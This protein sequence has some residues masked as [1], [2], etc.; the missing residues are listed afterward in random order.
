MEQISLQL[1]SA[2]LLLACAQAVEAQQVCYTT[3]SEGGSSAL[4]L[5]GTLILNDIPRQGLWAQPGDKELDWVGPQ[6][7]ERYDRGSSWNRDGERVTVIFGDGFS[8][9]RLSLL[10][11]GKSLAGTATYYADVPLPSAPY[12]IRLV[13]IACP[14]H[15]SNNSFKPKPLRGSA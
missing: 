11:S 8:G 13:P 3:I 9:L 6:N 15:R 14:S 1:A 7:K 2:L 4:E 12:S 5:P 10:P